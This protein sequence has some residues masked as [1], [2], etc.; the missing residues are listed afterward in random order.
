MEWGPLHPSLHTHTLLRNPTSPRIAT[1]SFSVLINIMADMRTRWLLSSVSSNTCTRYSINH[2]TVKKRTQTSHIK[3]N[4]AIH[5]LISRKVESV[6]DAVMTRPKC[7][8]RVK[9]WRP[10]KAKNF[11][12]CRRTLGIRCIP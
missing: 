1:A 5:F 8:W 3:Y 10:S 2:A 9:P 4:A 6:I 7:G 12:C 11:S